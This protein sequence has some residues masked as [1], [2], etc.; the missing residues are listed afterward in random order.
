MILYLITQSRKVMLSTMLLMI[1][2]LRL[3]KQ[4]MFKGIDKLIS[5]CGMN[6]RRGLLTLM[7]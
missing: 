5:I 7:N 2:A 4:T 1:L 6:L 3:I